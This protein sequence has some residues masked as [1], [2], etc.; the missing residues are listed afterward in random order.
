M[1]RSLLP[2]TLAVVLGCGASEGTLAPAGVGGTAPDDASTDSVGPGGDS[3]DAGSSGLD[4][5]GGQGGTGGAAGCGLTQCGSECVDTATNED[6][7]GSCGK[8]CDGTHGVR[9][10]AGG[11]CNISC[12]SGFADCD[13]QVDNG[14]E[15][16][17]DN[18]ILNCGAC[19]NDCKDGTCKGGSC[20]AATCD[21]AKKNGNET[22]IDCGGGGCKA[23]D[24]GEACASKEDC[25]SGV[26]EG[27]V[28][29]VPS[30]SDGVQNGSESDTDCGGS[31]QQCP[32][33]KKCVS[34]TDC[35]GGVCGADAKC[36]LARSCNELHAGQPALPTGQY[37]IDP[38]LVD[39]TMNFEVSCEMSTSGGGWMIV[40][41]DLP[42]AS[43]AECSVA[44]ID[45][46]G[47]IRVEAMDNPSPQGSTQHSGCG[48]WTT[49]RFYFREVL[50]VWYEWLFLSPYTPQPR[51]EVVRTAMIAPTE[52]WYPGRF[53]ECSTTCDIPLDKLESEIVKGAAYDLGNAEMFYLHFGVG[54]AGTGG[55]TTEIR[56][57]VR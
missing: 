23:C 53:A 22:D 10:C 9:S 56:I 39:L 26:C 24:A 42:T 40:N 14:C 46:T 35:L 43:G 37:A 2:A 41:S 13:K 18:D 16:Q 47:L 3:G 1:T 29:K 7:C 33:T 44:S 31:C 50:V 12:S 6:H 21:D 17:L 27:L 19:G 36:R 11:E 48:L 15:I 45:A 54:K 51:L 25:Q 8:V 57:L 5:S 32:L 38:D 20:A 28:C 34:A 55:T 30:C 52:N 4:A 49:E